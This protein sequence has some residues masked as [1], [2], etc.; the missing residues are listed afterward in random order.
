MASSID[1][2]VPVLL[3]PVL[4]GLAIRPDGTYVDATA[5]RGGHAAEILARLGTDGRLILLDRD[6]QAVAAC[7]D[8]FRGDAR[9]TVRHAPF[10]EL[11]S[12]LH[13]LEM[14]RVQGV[15]AD[16][17]VSSPQLDQAE[18]GFSFRQ[19]GPLDMRMDP[20]RGESA[21]A[22]LA[23]ASQ[24]EISQVLQEYG[25]ERFAWRIARAIV[26]AR[27]EKPLE[28]TTELAALVAKAVPS[29]EPGKDPATRSFQA[30]RMLINQELDELGT[31]LDQAGSVLAPGGRLAVISFHSL[32]DRMVKRFMRQ[33]AKG[34]QI[35][36][37]LPIPEI[38]IPSAPWRLVGKAVR[39]DAEEVARN[40]RARSAVLRIAERLDERQAGR[41]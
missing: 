39:A 6:P 38:Q 25:E 7:Q 32:E 5:G 8:R 10:S 24:E 21:A 18:R 30:I 19:T 2:H 36:P 13:T 33:G 28:S 11:E 12:V 31:L 3:Q 34:H 9:V 29:R 16:L 40:P 15:L 22:W 1:S 23:R 14:D 17:G 37:D 26:A 27:S 41:S 4:D 20:G 35:H